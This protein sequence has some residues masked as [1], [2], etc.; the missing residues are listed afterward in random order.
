MRLFDDSYLAYVW[1]Y[2]NI[3]YS[4]ISRVPICAS[5]RRGRTSGG[6]TTTLIYGRCRSLLVIVAADGSCWEQQQGRESPFL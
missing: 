5:A 3:R 6:R 2:L 4:F 1:A